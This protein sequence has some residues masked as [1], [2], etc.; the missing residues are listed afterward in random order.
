MKRQSAFRLRLIAGNLA[1]GGLLAAL[2]CLLPA[3]T[4]AETA[5][6][7]WVQR[8]NGPG[9]SAD[10]ANAIAVDGS[11]NVVVTGQSYATN[12]FP[13]HATIKYSG[14]GVLVGKRPALGRMSTAGSRGFSGYSAMGKCARWLLPFIVCGL[15]LSPYPAPPLAAFHLQCAPAISGPFANIPGATSPYTN[16]ITGD[17][18]FFG[19][20]H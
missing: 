16:P 8:Y 10:S 1:M 12:G 11:N 9:N 14:A 15:R 3:H 18:Q 4:R 17:R 2:L 19:L 13:D 5:V 20:L 7:A 6:H